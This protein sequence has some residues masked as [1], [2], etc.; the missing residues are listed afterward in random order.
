M[1]IYIIDLYLI[2]SQVEIVQHVDFTDFLINAL[3]LV[4]VHLQDLQLLQIEDC[5]R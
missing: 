2:V 5:W 3:Y 4:V 1:E